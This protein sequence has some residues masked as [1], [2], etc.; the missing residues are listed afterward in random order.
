MAILFRGA[1]SELSS[2]L[3]KV[4]KFGRETHL[5]EGNAHLPKSSGALSHQQVYLE[6]WRHRMGY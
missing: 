6:A 1:Y 2:P 3:N 4:Q 5:V